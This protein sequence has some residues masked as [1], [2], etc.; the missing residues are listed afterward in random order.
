MNIS[1]RKVKNPQ[2]EE[3]YIFA[4]TDID[5]HNIL[6]SDTVGNL[7]VSRNSG[8]SFGISDFTNPVN[9]MAI[10]GWN[11]QY[12]ILENAPGYPTT[13]TLY[14]SNAWLKN[15]TSFD[16]DPTETYYHYYPFIFISENGVRILI[17]E[18]N[19]AVANCKL[20]Y[21]SNFGASFTDICPIHP[22]SAEEN[23]VNQ[24]YMSRDGSTIMVC[25]RA[26]DQPARIYKSTNGGVGWSTTVSQYTTDNPGIYES[27]CSY[28]GLF[29]VTAG[30]NALSYSRYGSWYNRPLSV[31]AQFFTNQVAT[32][33]VFVQ[34][35]NPC[36]KEK[37][38]VS[39]NYF[40]TSEESYVMS[41]SSW[42]AE[43]LSCN[44]TFDKFVLSTYSYDRSAGELY[45]GVPARIKS[46]NSVPFSQS[47]EVVASI[48]RN[49]LDKV[50][51]EQK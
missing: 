2:W 7:Y 9:L 3:D 24:V 39:E 8:A 15:W 34:V 28:N 27:Y 51:L 36:V 41:D 50:N 11:A 48:N 49:E 47:I 12:S 30:A 20:L 6:V 35:E 21:S 10:G 38:L 29:A 43:T 25:E 23:Y 13:A 37:I 40:I 17:Y 33:T 26:M 42:I 16:P 46:V 5:C 32:K 14:K 44:R 22:T 4:A 1:W 31:Y 45:L 18:W 19:I